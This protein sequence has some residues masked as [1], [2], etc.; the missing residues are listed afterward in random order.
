MCSVEVFITGRCMLLW[1][2]QGGGSNSARQETP[3]P[4]TLS[5]L[6]S[7]ER[8]RICA[9]RPDAASVEWSWRQH[10]SKSGR[11]FCWK[12]LQ[13]R[14]TQC[15][16]CLAKC[17]RRT[18]C[19]RASGVR[20]AMRGWTSCPL[21]VFWNVSEW[22]CAARTDAGRSV[23]DGVSWWVHRAGDDKYELVALVQ[24]IAME[25]HGADGGHYITWVR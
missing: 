23:W 2:F 25:Q 19:A 11:W 14:A 15:T 6:Q 10:T 8:R 16:P 21:A 20:A 12:M 24:H 9:R 13:Q 18:C 4:Q 5:A 17:R 22:R 1:L 7:L 3:S